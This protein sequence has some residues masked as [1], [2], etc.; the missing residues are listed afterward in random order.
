MLLL[1]VIYL[2][3]N[4]YI[5]FECEKKADIVM[6]RS[7]PPCVL[8]VVSKYH[9]HLVLSPTEPHEIL[10]FLPPLESYYYL[11]GKSVDYQRI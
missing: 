3:D 8:Y 1:L 4:V 11:V 5:I 6:V 10:L 2:T 9:S 7:V